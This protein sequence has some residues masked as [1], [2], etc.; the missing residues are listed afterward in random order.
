[1]NYATPI[2]LPILFSRQNYHSSETLLH[3]Y[4]T[5]RRQYQK[6]AS[7]TKYQVDLGF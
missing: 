6:H 3:I 5:K 4:Q 2:K 1:M 7:T